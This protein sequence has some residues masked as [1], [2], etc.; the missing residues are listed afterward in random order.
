MS[1]KFIVERARFHVQ[2]KNLFVIQVWFEDDTKGNEKFKVYLDG[3]RAKMHVTKQQG[4]EV[5]NK[6]LRYKR[7]IELEYF[8]WIE[9]PESLEHCKQLV[10]YRSLEGKPQ[11]IY[12]CSGRSLLRKQKSVLHWVD[13]VKKTE[14]NQLAI[15]GW[16]VSHEPVKFLVLDGSKKPIEYQLDLQNRSDVQREFPEALPEEAKGFEL[17]F[18]GEADSYS[19]LSLHLD[20]G[21]RNFAKKIHV[22]R[23]LSDRVRPGHYVKIGLE[24]LERNGFK[25]FLHRI[26]QK[27]TR[28]D[29]IEYAAWIKKYGV[30]EQELKEQRLEKFTNG[31]LFSIVVPLY[32]TKEELL[33]EMIRSVQEQTYK[34]WELCLS[35]GSGKDSPL[36]EIL[37]RYANQDSR[38]KPIHNQEQLQISENTNRALDAASG[39]YV[40]FADH[41]DLLSPDALYECVSAIQKKPETEVL[42]SDEDKVDLSG[43]KYFQPHF[44]SDFNMDLLCSMNYISHLFV[45]KRELMERIGRLRAEFDGAQDYDFIL[46]CIEQTSHIHHIS[47]VLYHWRAHMD[48][49]AE[50]PESK[51]YAFEAGRRAVQAHYDRLGINARVEQGE[52]PGLYRSYYEIENAPL[53]SIVIPN[54]DHINDLK[55]CIRS[56]EEKSSYKNYEYIIVENN[57]TEQ[58]TFDYYKQ[59][60]AENPKVHVVYYKGKFNYSAINNFGASK[61]AGAYFLLLNNDTEI[62]NEDCIKELLGYCTREEVGAVGARLYYGDDIIQHAGVVV[63]F[64]GIAGH[65]F[66]GSSRFEN[67]YFSRIICAQDYSAVTAACMMLKRTV[68]EAVGGLSEELE[69]AFNDI[70]LCMKIR[71]EGKLIVYNPYAELYHY[72][73]KSRG[74]ENTQEKVERFNQEMAH[75]IEKW[76]V[77]MKEGD[78]YYNQNLTLDKADFSLKA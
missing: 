65:A 34:N 23:E 11:R 16:Y 3:Q 70:D 53:V 44:K 42:Y 76:P 62:I 15:T 27:T 55:N 75:F 64:G 71:A 25:A 8:I 5:H 1:K 74:Q 57:S 56:I 2:H 24:Y 54:K 72:E 31:P 50:N 10:V 60:E 37:N 33:R 48:S 9:L 17:K 46:R 66:I 7:N 58:E 69:V 41:D 19:S 49:T 43:K 6:Y 4:A 22:K 29:K 32:K 35:D 51:K 28:Q 18:P 77:I 45:I 36:T 52:Y 30:T 26:Y 67:G 20:S 13:N 12:S 63:G 59:L 40:V 38:I 61:A 68:F 47:K 73:S 21:L 39:D 14:N 78:P